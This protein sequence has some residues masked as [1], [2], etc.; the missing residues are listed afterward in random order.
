M[1][2]SKMFGNKLTSLIVYRASSPKPTSA[3]AWKMSPERRLL[4]TSYAKKLSSQM[5]IFHNFF[6]LLVLSSRRC[7][8]SSLGFRAGSL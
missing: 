1:F 3:K 4:K 6:L 5:V 2:F 7:G 8:D